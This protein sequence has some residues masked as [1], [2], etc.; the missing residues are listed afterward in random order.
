MS[1]PTTLYTFSAY[2]TVL[3]A[4]QTRPGHPKLITKFEIHGVEIPSGSS[5]EFNFHL[6]KSKNLYPMENSRKNFLPMENSR[7]NFHP[8]ENSRKN[9]HPMENSRKFF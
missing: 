7:K 4:T 1:G 3:A 8:M 9:F 6:L 2:Y 5:M